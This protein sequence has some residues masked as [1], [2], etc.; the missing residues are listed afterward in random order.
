[1][2]IKRGLA[3]LLTFLMIL[4]MTP[5][6][7]LAD[8]DDWYAT[9]TWCPSDRDD[10]RH[11][12]LDWEVFMDATCTWDGFMTRK[13]YFCH[14]EQT[15]II[16]AT[17][18]E[19]GSWYTFK[20]PTCTEPGERV[21]TCHDCGE[22]E[23]EDIPAKGHTYGAWETIE[24]PTCTKEGRRRRF[25]TTCG[26][27]EFDTMAKIPHVFGP[28]FAELEPTCT[29][30]GTNRR[31][32]T[33]C[34]AVERETVPAL[35]HQVTDW[36]I[37]KPMT[38]FSYG[39]REGTCS[40]CGQIQTEELIPLGILR[41][42]DNGTA[43]QKLQAALNAAGFNCGYADGAFGGNTESAVSGFEGT[44]GVGQDGIAWPGV[45]NAL[46]NNPASPTP[47]GAI[48]LSLNQLSPV[49]EAY[50]SGENVDY[51][52]VFSNYTS[53]AV[54]NWNLY[55]SENVVESGKP[56]GWSSPE[57]GLGVNINP[58]ETATTKFTY[59]ITD[60]DVKAG[61]EALHW[62]IVGDLGGGESAYSNTY[63]LAVPTMET[64]APEPEA[65]PE[66]T[67][68]ETTGPET[69]EPAAAGP[70]TEGPGGMGGP[71][72]EITIKLEGKTEFPAHYTEGDY[73]EV[74][75]TLTNESEV[76]VLIKEFLTDPEDM[77]TYETW[78]GDLLQPHMS[79]AFTARVMAEAPDISEGII[80]AYVSVT[81]EEPE[82]HLPAGA[83]AKIQ[84][85]QILDKPGILLV[86]EDTSGI[87]ASP[88]DD[89]PVE[90]TVFNIGNCDMMIDHL[91]VASCG[92]AEDPSASDSYTIP[93]EVFTL[94]KQEDSFKFTY[95]I[96]VTPSDVSYGMVTRLFW[97]Y[98]KDVAT[99]T[100]EM[101]IASV[102]IPLEG[103]EETNLAAV[104]L[105][106]VEINYPG[107]L[108]APGGT[109]G[110]L[111]TAGYYGVVRNTGSV[112]IKVDKLQV[113]LYP[114]VLTP[115]TVKDYDPVMELDPDE[116]CGFYAK[117][118]LNINNMIPAAPEDSLA[119]TIQADFFVTACNPDNMEPY[120]DSNPV[121]FTYD[122]EKAFEPDPD[123]GKGEEPVLSA[124]KYVV[125]SPAFDPLGFVEGETIKYGITVTNQTGTQVDEVFVYDPLKGG[126][127]DMLVDTIMPLGPY[128]SE[129][130]YFDYV[131]KPE[132]V[133]KGHVENTAIVSWIWEDNSIDMDTNTVNVDTV[134]GQ[135]SLTIEKRVTK[136]PD[137][138][139]YFVEGET[140]HY[141]IYIKNE[142]GDTIYVTVSD[143]LIDPS[144][145]IL[146]TVYTI[147]DGSFILIPYGYVV[148]D[149]DV[150]STC[151]KN[152]AL[153]K[154]TNSHGIEFSRSTNEVTVPTGEP[155]PEVTVTKTETS[156]PDNKTYYTEGET[157]T[158]QI[159]VENTGKI[160]LDEVIVLDSLKDGSGEI[161]SIELFDPGEKFT[162]AFSHVVTKED[163]DA[164]KVIN[165]ATVEYLDED[166]QTW[167]FKSEDVVSPTGKDIPKE[168]TPKEE[169]EPDCC[170]WIL[171]G[172]GTGQEETRLEFCT[173]HKKIEDKARILIEAASPE[174]LEDA[175]KQAAE[176]WTEALNTEYDEL[177][178]KAIPDELPILVN[179]KATFYIQLDCRTEAL[180]KQYPDEPLKALQFRAEQLRKKCT[181]LCYEMHTAPGYRRD[182]F[183][184]GSY[185]DIPD[186]EKLPEIC[187]R[188]K[189]EEKNGLKIREVLT[190]NYQMIQEMVRTLAGKAEST[191][192]L[193]KAWKNA[194]QLW[195]LEMKALLNQEYLSADEEGKS[196]LEAEMTSFNKWLSAR[197]SFL[198]LLYPGHPEIT[199]EVLAKTI[200][201]RLL[202]FCTD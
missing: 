49:K 129:T 108:T 102:S 84:I 82:S 121:P 91:E 134:K 109:D 43:V 137:N 140:V 40:M 20:S 32:C 167:Q 94:F 10:H 147:P 148:T 75:L 114:D 117:L 174:K 128:A 96:K 41:R 81:V 104:K 67:E 105:I 138:K 182:S 150:S 159:D 161:A 36:R 47:V 80:H 127:E 23:Y 1:M 11:Y 158:Y 19:W 112:P 56:N 97:M 130:V 194:A 73:V 168:E 59:T 169:P 31:T 155:L 115:V 103:K 141:E 172:V 68:P 145:P 116:S 180:E 101:Y 157:I 173:S 78:M 177:L 164:G 186:L 185:A 21:R 90:I 190:E 9:D 166:G 58:G 189:T 72:F 107:T 87:V 50:M 18:H 69:T 178:A 133:E 139:S 83:S 181:E 153:V 60:L 196:L 63:D 28:V 64:P 29:A 179:E 35:P 76:P 175:W 38:P 79:Y 92:A 71:G 34:G 66:T 126:E 70:E 85:P 165:T 193:V 42:G 45:Q 171:T 119:G 125:N 122:V 77:V 106:L 25:C 201:N 44:I 46:Y 187:E 154:F 61:G 144:D 95:N 111:G 120:C 57:S 135:G 146:T 74:P 37:T 143:P 124:V 162:Y 191:D 39:L 195:K 123:A 200:E 132:D 26:E 13:C 151:I 197:E 152:I 113:R 51:E 2:K 30:A 24:L 160:L 176:F 88:D 192:Q 65:T 53:K 156:D 33:V 100:K 17:G 12:F 16:P 14:Y 52:L 198:N 86:P 118:P 98:A 89:I 27:V 136:M 4:G 7:A 202:D 142:T 62:Y 184:T 188:I 22:E 110:H 99:G 54:K 170:R 55:Y 48:V 5:V 131:V 199:A 163:V 8:E 93:P 183:I 149:L 6:S 15:K 3:I